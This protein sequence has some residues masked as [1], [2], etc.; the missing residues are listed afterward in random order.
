MQI[1]DRIGRAVLA[2]AVA[3]AA[4]GLGGC[5]ALVYA[6]PGNYHESHGPVETDRDAQAEPQRCLSR[7][8]RL[9]GRQTGGTL[10]PGLAQSWPV[11][12]ARIWTAIRVD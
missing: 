2:A 8:L 10:R 7:V 5:G 1:K 6:V 12:R 3:V 9:D 11:F 4:S